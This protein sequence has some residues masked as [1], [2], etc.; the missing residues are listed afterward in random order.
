MCKLDIR[1]RQE[2]GEIQ[3]TAC[4]TWLWFGYI[5][6]IGKT[7]CVNFSERCL[8]LLLEIYFHCTYNNITK[9]KQTSITFSMSKITFF[10]YYFCFG[11]FIFSNVLKTVALPSHYLKNGP[12]FSLPLLHW[13]YL[14][15]DWKN[16]AG[17]GHQACVFM[18]TCVAK[19]MLLPFI[20]D[21]AC[22]GHVTLFLNIP[23]CTSYELTESSKTW[24]LPGQA[25]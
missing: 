24:H 13:F 3:I 9:I 20:P 11:V 4:R 8:T 2:H 23:T 21:G 16:R 19:Q 5:N 10:N 7:T 14:V 12:L 6:M 22:S 17:S 25:Q 15:I 18:S 1:Y